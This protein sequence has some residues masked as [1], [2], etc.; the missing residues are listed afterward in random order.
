MSYLVE[1]YWPGEPAVQQAVREKRREA[2]FGIAPS[3][4]ED[5]KQTSAAPVI[6]WTS[7]TSARLRLAEQLSRARCDR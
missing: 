6:E 3:R 2:I 1:L 4:G 5:T 7:K